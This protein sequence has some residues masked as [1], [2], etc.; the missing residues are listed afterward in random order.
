MAEREYKRDEKGR[1][2]AEDSKGAKEDKKG[3]ARQR[4]LEVSKGVTRVKF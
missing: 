3:T 4:L 2:A 1:F